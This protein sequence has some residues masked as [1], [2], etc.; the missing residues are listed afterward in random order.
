MGLL[1]SI[2]KVFSNPRSNVNEKTNEL[3]TN[4]EITSNEEI[5]P[6]YKTE[7][8]NNLLPGEIVLLDWLSGKSDD[9]DYPKYFSY[10]YGI[11]PHRST[12]KLIKQGYLEYASALESISTLKVSEL[13][14]ILRDN[15]LKLSGNKS[16]LVD[17]IKNNFSEEMIKKYIN[18]LSLKTTEKGENTFKEFYYIV[19]AHKNGSKD[20]VYNVA[21]AIHFVNNFKG[22]FTPLNRDISWG[23]YQKEYLNEMKKRNFGM[24]RNIVLSMAKQ[25]EKR[26]K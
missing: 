7:L 1:N 16:L 4:I 12:E 2:K 8:T 11:D 18:N 15:D 6:I 23:I 14:E 24:A 13:K 21:S 17:R 3:N 26:R 10:N 20:G 5:N 9:G 25:V 22:S 19:P